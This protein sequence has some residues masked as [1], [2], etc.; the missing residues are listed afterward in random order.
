MHQEYWRIQHGSKIVMIY[1]LK[2]M[3]N[4]KRVVTKN[5]L[6]QDGIINL[7]P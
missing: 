1:N 6:D 5:K 4:K 2:K 7:Q 3:V